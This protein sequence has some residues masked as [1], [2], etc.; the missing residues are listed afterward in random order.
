MTD[1][2]E[3]QVRAPAP[4][5]P[6][7]VQRRS[8]QDFPTADE[9]S[10]GGSLTIWLGA[11]ADE[12]I[13]W[14]INVAERDRQLR[15]F[16][17][18]EPTLASAIYNV[19][20]QNATFEWE[21]EGPPRTTAAVQ[22]LLKT[23][24][25]GAGYENFI[26]K[27]TADLL[28][29]DNGWWFEIIRTRDS[30]TA[31][32][33]GLNH[34]DSGRVTR[35]GNPIEPAVYFDRLGRRHLMKW[36]QIVEISELPS[37]IEAMY[38]VQYSAVTRILRAAQILRDIGI[39]KAEKVGGRFT[40]EIN[41]IGGVKQSDIDD[42]RAMGQE[43]ADNRG[44][45]RY[46]LPLIL[47][48]LDPQATVSSVNIPL[49]S[50]PD[51][52]DMDEELK[53]YITTIAS[54]LGRDYQDFAPL[55]AGNIGT[56]TQSMI[57]H[58]KAKGKGP[59]LFIRLISDALNRRGVIPRNV[60]FRIT[61][62]DQ[63][64]QVERAELGRVRADTRK[65]QIDSGEISPMIARQL[66]ADEGDLDPKYLALL[67]EGDLTPDQV[68]QS[69][70]KPTIPQ[71][72]AESEL[73]ARGAQQIAE[74]LAAGNGATPPPPPMDQASIVKS[75]LDNAGYWTEAQALE[76][77]DEESSR[78]KA[79]M[80][81]AMG[82]AKAETEQ[83][84]AVRAIKDAIAG[85]QTIL[86]QD[87][88]PAPIVVNVP[89]AQVTVQIPEQP[90]PEIVIQIPEQPAPVVN[91]STPAVT[92]NPEITVTSPRTRET[93]TV[94][95]RDQFGKIRKVEKIQEEEE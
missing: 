79:T 22:E 87:S 82:A 95:E 15:E 89:P 46:M 91:V 27:G 20:A 28:T 76:A 52:F 43:E 41:V 80:L 58:Q 18:T 85:I 92:V 4:D 73:A 35:T 56:S 38:G 59:G 49:A 67:G 31:P 69:F 40:R 71:I 7:Q 6:L 5:L 62:Q 50:L 63:A 13:P 61:F 44:Q 36:Y 19:I 51:N 94:T 64:D 65:T 26:I 45:R 33:I 54:G 60:N 24:N 25:Q 21:L 74:D 78:L 66:A 86:K 81:R 37:P 47:T 23:A 9:G 83:G 17:P 8:V 68:L 39:Y 29:Q 88:E 16:W 57:L 84:Q 3:K 93:V 55:P 34:L 48:T 42:I 11:I 10:R 70:E 32:V 12:F 72:A 14:G 53:W 30:K 77:I 90:A 75:W 1:Q 2:N